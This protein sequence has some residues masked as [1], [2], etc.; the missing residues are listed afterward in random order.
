MQTIKQLRDK[1]NKID[2]DIVKKLAQRKALSI[3]IG[4]AKAK[5]NLKIIDIKREKLLNDRYDKLSS[6]HQLQSL[7]IKKIFKIIVKNSRGLQK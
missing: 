7:F 2:A 5:S 3:K 4:K 6:K 1:I